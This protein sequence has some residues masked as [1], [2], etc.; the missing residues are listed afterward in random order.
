MTLTADRKPLGQIIVELRPDVVPKTA[1]NFRVLCTG[2]KGFGYAGSTFHRI[3][4][5]FMVQGGDFSNHDG[6][7]GHR[8]VRKSGVRSLVRLYQ[9]QSLILAL[10]PFGHLS[11]KIHNLEFN[12]TVPTGKMYVDTYVKILK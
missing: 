5:K 8:L 6:T 9:R 3:I 10:N 1:E 7:G 2:E 11:L 12:I 4:P